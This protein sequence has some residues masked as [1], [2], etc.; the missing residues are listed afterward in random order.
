MATP[1]E[2]IR[3]DIEDNTAI[4]VVINQWS[5]STSEETL[6][7]GL[8][9]IGSTYPGGKTDLTVGVTSRSSIM[10][11]ARDNAIAIY[12]FYKNIKGYGKTLPAPD[13]TGGVALE[14]M[15]ILPAGRPVA[16]Q[17]VGD[18][19]DWSFN[20]IVQFSDE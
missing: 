18:H 10:N 3:Q 11:T 7:Q 16:L 13:Y 5:V 17:Q 4:T 6:L 14:V 9:G 2:N 15:S 20:L 1:I 12:D 8:G 19:Y